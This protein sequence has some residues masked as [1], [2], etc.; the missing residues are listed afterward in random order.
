MQY[1]YKNPLPLYIYRDLDKLINCD[2]KIKVRESFS[3]PTLNT[4]SATASINN[5]CHDEK[6]W[7]PLLIDFIKKKQTNVIAIDSNF[8]HILTDLNYYKKPKTSRQNITKRKIQGDGTCLNSQISLSIK[9]PE[10]HFRP[11]KVYPIKLFRNG[12]MQIPGILKEDLSDFIPIIDYLC[13]FIKEFIKSID[14]KVFL[15]KYVYPI[16]KEKNIKNIQDFFDTIKLKY[17]SISARNYKYSLLPKDGRDRSIDRNRL[18]EYYNDKINK[19]LNI[20][21]VE[22][23][24]YFKVKKQFDESE[25]INKILNNNEIKN[26]RTSKKQLLSC[27]YNS[28]IL[29]IKAKIYNIVNA[30]YKISNIIYDEDVIID[31]INKTVDHMLNNIL[32]ELK[33]SNDNRLAS[34]SNKNSKKLIIRFKSPRKTNKKKMTTVL[35]HNKKINIQAAENPKEAESIFYEIGSVI[36]NHKNNIMYY[37]DMPINNDFDDIIEEIKLINID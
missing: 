1:K 33:T 17:I 23:I 29:D 12:K 8:G 28:A 7:T 30:M 20:S 25:F 13:Y 27:I 9:A 19:Y 32:D 15:D 18:Y 37:D 14:D 31:I 6:Y 3:F 16:M 36:I 22:F 2:E 26:I 34:V 24:K 35:I 11:N 10:D 4:L 5:V 21:E